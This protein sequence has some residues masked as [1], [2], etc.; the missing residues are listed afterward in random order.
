ML[1]RHAIRPILILTVA[2]ML[3]PVA[4]SAP[5]HDDPV[6][7]AQAA[8]AR[9]AAAQEA[10]DLEAAGRELA[11]ALDLLADLPDD[12]EITDVLK[13]IHEGAREI[14]DHRTAHAAIRRV[15]AHLAETLPG[16]HLD[17]ARHRAQLGSVLQDLGDLQGALALQ[18]QVLS[19]FERALDEEH[20]ELAAIRFQ[21]G[22]LLRQLG[23]P[24][25][26]RSLQER[27]LAAYEKALP[28]DHP[29]LAEA[30]LSLANTFRALGDPAATRPLE[31][32]A[33]RIYEKNRTPDH[34]DLDWLRSNLA[35]TLFDLGEFQGAREILEALVADQE[36]SPRSDDLAL[37]WS[38]LLLAGTLR[39]LG[40]LAGSRN[41]LDTL[42]EEF[43][44]GVQRNHPLA[45]E[46]RHR[47]SMVLLD[48]RELDRAMSFQQEVL[49]ARQA[50]LPPDHPDL[51]RSREVVSVILME[52]GD[53]R[54]ARI[55]LESALAGLEGSLPDSHP[56]LSTMLNNLG[57]MLRQLGDL[58]AARAVQERV[59][60]AREATLPA[61]HP[62]LAIARSNL[63]QTLMTLRD[64]AAAKPLQEQALASLERAYP[65]GHDQ[66][67]RARGDLG[68]TLSELGDLAGARALQEQ[69]F[70]WD[71]LHLPANHP[72]RA[73]GRLN[74]ATT[75]RALGDPETARRL[76]EE[77][78]AMLER[79][80]PDGHP[81]FASA[82]NT[83]ATIL[84]DLGELEAARAL[85]REILA[86]RERT[87]PGHHPDLSIA[88]S[89]LAGTLLQLGELEAARSLQE[90][91]L[92]TQQQIQPEDHPELAC[93]RHHLA[94]TLLRI[95]D[96]EA[97]GRVAREFL[98]G[99]QASASILPISLSP[100][101]AEFL[102]ARQANHLDIAYRF[103]R[104]L[105]ELGPDVVRLI[106]SFRAVGLTPAAL[107][108]SIRAQGGDS[109]GP[110]FD[111]V[112][113][114]S[115]ELTRLARA[116]ERDAMTRALRRRDEAQREMLEALEANGTT[117]SIL[118]PPTVRDLAATLEQGEFL[119]SY[120]VAKGSLLAH[121]IGPDH[122][123]RATSLQEIDK[124]DR[125]A[126]AVAAWRTL[127]AAPVD[128]GQP[129]EVLERNAD[130]A[131]ARGEELR[132][133]VFDPIDRW[134]EGAR[135]IVF[136]PADV[137]HAVPLDALPYGDSVLGER[138]DVE[139]RLTLRERLWTRPAADGSG[140]LL[141]LGGASFN[142]APSG[143]DQADSQD[144][145]RAA[146]M[147][148]E[149]WERSFSPLPYTG[150]EARG[151]AA[152][153]DE[154]FGDEE[155]AGS[156]AILLERSRASRDQVERQAPGV[157]FLHVATHG[158]FAPE[159]IRSWNDRETPGA[160]HV[161]V[162]RMSLEE[163]VRGVSP[164]VLCG[165]ALAGANLP[166]DARG[167]SPGLV[168]AEEIAS[169]DLS[170]C[171]LAVLSACD[172]NVGVRRA[173]QGVAS[174]Q[175]ALHMAGA[176]SV[177]T[178]LWKV[179]DEA[180]QELMLDFY[181]RL[182]IEGK[183]K[184]QALWEAKMRIRDAR[185]A[186]GALRYSTR[187]WAA[188]VLTGEPE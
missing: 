28:P 129:L 122:R 55:Q 85:Q 148:D 154:T 72:D 143:E 8:V 161:A 52:K 133:L 115:A 27:G 60:A 175:K 160:T 90:R 87:L 187:D 172:T 4:A 31:E 170:G 16:D 5:S 180:T 96:D 99:L 38:R 184:S 74:L 141:A 19:T 156:A 109:F 105:P 120:W 98:D 34:P 138:F 26:A 77:G 73:I 12:T 39:Q 135:R 80:Y 18:R 145:A 125:I 67:S 35:G 151:V 132:K 97:F 81:G 171:E 136:V 22:M 51:A 117:A 50:T 91:A 29:Q 173:G 116:G 20:E 119:V 49:E 54:G 126:E 176:R 30:Y 167:R 110:L 113:E 149:S 71:E 44:P 157:R 165:L 13:A 185:D 40:D 86:Y 53:F 43:P 124:V 163:Q 46:A 144:R 25:A 140:A 36:R 121:V 41:L 159:S 103:A 128:R 83:L 47:L 84:A 58:A 112:Q 131:R 179:P 45:I 11:A 59:L 70:E 162:P 21:V 169:W 182:W 15:V 147:K 100:R 57:V 174:L 94:D 178:S 102:A 14:G 93:A 56:T 23:D 130:L 127:I 139:L 7:D 76:A 168:T 2:T 134:L 24:E 111:E 62:D 95:G 10:A 114:A 75:L 118:R 37:P 48:L 89:N 146:A 142:R 108:A 158:W 88:R 3:A 183:P 63:A 123:A 64:Y 188:W 155:A 92:A 42:L 9:A 106:E 104:N 61:D 68:L 137:L 150:T 181:R 65:Q 164:M 107:L 177:I 32:R 152:L 33:L 166:L 79:T 153:F 78:V 17:L 82:R 186:T 6:A 1:L 69:A 101:E 66:V